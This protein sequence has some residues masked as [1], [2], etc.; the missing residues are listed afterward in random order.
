MVWIPQKEKVS[1]TR[2]RKAFLLRILQLLTLNLFFS[3]RETARINEPINLSNSL[4]DFSVW[5]INIKYLSYAVC[6]FLITFESMS[7]SGPFVALWWC[8]G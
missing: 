6:V 1:Q 5:N 3:F 4:A 8:W 7:A 2:P